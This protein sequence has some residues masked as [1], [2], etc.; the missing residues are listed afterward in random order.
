[1]YVYILY[2]Y[3]ALSLLYSLM[4]KLHYHS[5]YFTPSFDLLPYKL[6]MVKKDVKSK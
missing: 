2:I 4:K 3:T 1:M 6:A 5:V